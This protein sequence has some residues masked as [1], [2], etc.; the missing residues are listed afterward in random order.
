MDVEFNPLGLLYGLFIKGE[1]RVL[2]TAKKFK[3]SMFGYRKSDVNG[4][5]MNA[6]REYE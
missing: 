1:A 2:E 6:A 4:Y 5:I 3:G